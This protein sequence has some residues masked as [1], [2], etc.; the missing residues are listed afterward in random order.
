MSGYQ[1]HDRKEVKS[2]FG[3]SAEA[4]SAGLN[5][6][7]ADQIFFR[8]KQDSVNP[9]DRDCSLEGDLLITGNRYQR[10]GDELV[11]VEYEFETWHQAIQGQKT[12]S[13]FEGTVEVSYLGQEPIDSEYEKRVTF[14]FQSSTVKNLFQVSLAYLHIKN[15][16]SIGN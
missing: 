11:E 3:D 13:P 7:H 2:Y 12:E 10:T 15:P 14:L 9:D 1:I 5:F 16:D 8:V 6:D 4:L